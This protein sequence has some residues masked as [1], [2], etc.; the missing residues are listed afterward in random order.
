MLEAAAEL[1]CTASSPP[2]SCLLQVE[3]KGVVTAECVDNSTKK[4]GG[5]VTRGSGSRFGA[6]GA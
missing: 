2:P 6:G 4:V 1:T 5:H 3:L